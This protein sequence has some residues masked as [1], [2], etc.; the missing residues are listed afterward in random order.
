MSTTATVVENVPAAWPVETAPPAPACGQGWF[1]LPFVVP[2][3]WLAPRHFGPSVAATSWPKAIL[4]HLLAAAATVLLFA[5]AGRTSFDYPIAGLTA[6][7][8][9]RLPFVLA[10]DDMMLVTN[11]FGWRVL[12]PVL[13]IWVVLPIFAW[14]LS[15]TQSVGQLRRTAYAAALKHLLWSLSLAVPLAI[16]TLVVQHLARDQDGALAGVFKH[17]HG[18]QLEIMVALLFLLW[19]LRSVLLLGE[20][21]G[22]TARGPAWAPRLPLCVGCG[23]LLTGLPVDGRCPECGAPV[24]DSSPHARRL[25]TWAAVRWAWPLGAYWRTAWQVFRDRTFFARLPVYAGHAA[26]RRFATASGWAVAALVLAVALYALARSRK[27]HDLDLGSLAAMILVVVVVS[28]VAWR[29]FLI[30][31]AG[32]AGLRD[33][34]VAAAVVTGY[35]TPFFWPALLLASAATIGLFEC[36]PV[37]IAYILER[38]TGLS[39]GWGEPLVTMAAVIAALVAVIYALVRY[40]RALKAVRWA[41]A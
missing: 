30:L 2:L 26:A 14:F 20:R 36:N 15:V 6:S 24:A 33:R 12:A 22:G 10:L 18:D 32:F 31:L 16:A 34:P 19:G 1:V 28:S 8:R 9:I 25:P 27:E 21:Y 7:E 23:Y 3:S 4:L 37:R 41:S 39:I 5:V 35:A 11:Q 13:L 40:G 29:V 38:Y 17:F